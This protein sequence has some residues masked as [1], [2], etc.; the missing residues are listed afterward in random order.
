MSQVAL[1]VRKHTADSRLPTEEETGKHLTCPLEKNGIKSWE[2]VLHQ[3]WIVSTCKEASIFNFEFLQMWNSPLLVQANLIT[4][5]SS[6]N[7]RKGRFLQSTAGADKL[8]PPDWPGESLVCTKTGKTQPSGALPPPLALLQ[9]LCHPVG[10]PAI[11]AAGT[12]RLW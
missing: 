12:V 2:R 5:A 4:K 8:Q 1:Q 10:Q 3:R 9:T 7:S 6:N 11:V